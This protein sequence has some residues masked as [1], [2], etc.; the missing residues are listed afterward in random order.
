VHKSDLARTNVSR[1]IARI[2][3]ILG[4]PRGRL[5]RRDVRGHPMKDLHIAAEPDVVF[6]YFT[7]AE[8]LARWIG[9]RATVDP[10]PGRQ[11]TIVF[12]DRSVEGRYLEVE[13]PQ[14][15]RD[16]MG[17]AGSK[18]FP[19]ESSVL[20]VTL[21]S[22]G[23]GTLVAIVHTG[24]PDSELHRHVLGWEHYFHRLAVVAAGGEPDPHTTPASLTEGVD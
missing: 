4:S 5:R 20:E 16:F 19:A 22:R 2:R 23:G 8:A 17:R 6:E 3:G 10:R 18:E 14:A 9:D 13:T 24:L 12:G 1:W 11:F 15:T 21:T 7:K